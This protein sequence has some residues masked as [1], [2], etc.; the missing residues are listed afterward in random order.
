MEIHQTAR[1]HGVSDQ[2]I[3]HA[4]D[5]ALTWVEVGEDPQRY[6]VAGPNRAGNLLELVILMTPTVEL[7]IH[8]MKI[9][10]SSEAQ[11]FGGEGR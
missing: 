9:R 8:A 11:L 4:Y 10:P 6:L 5:H 7:V 2:D 3:T 1:K